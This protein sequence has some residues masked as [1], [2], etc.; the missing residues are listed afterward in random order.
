M[1]REASAR[2]AALA[3]SWLRVGYNQGNFNGDNCLVGG[4]TWFILRKR[5][6][7]R[8][9]EVLCNTSPAPS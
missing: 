1:L 7:L 8:G 6:Q 4:A 3:A 5:R 2:F 9:L